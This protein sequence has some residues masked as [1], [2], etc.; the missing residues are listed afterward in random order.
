MEDEDLREVDYLQKLITLSVQFD[1]HIGMFLLD[2]LELTEGEA[3]ELDNLADLCE[4][5]KIKQELLKEKEKASQELAESEEIQHHRLSHRCPLAPA[6]IFMHGHGPELSDRIP[7]FID[8]A[9]AARGQ[10]RERLY[11]AW[12]GQREEAAGARFVDRS[13]EV[14]HLQRPLALVFWGVLQEVLDPHGP[15]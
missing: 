15:E 14:E 5:E 12:V 8:V 6:E 4:L 10:Q 9:H 7:P 2:L 13:Q 3:K 11:G 1:H